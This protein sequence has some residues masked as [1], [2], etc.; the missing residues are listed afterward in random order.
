[1][2]FKSFDFSS[3]PFFTQMLKALDYYR[4]GNKRGDKR[5]TGTRSLASMNKMFKWISNEADVKALRLY[6]STGTY[7]FVCDHF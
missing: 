7:S 1:M 2:K 5:K 6:E 4:S 3:L